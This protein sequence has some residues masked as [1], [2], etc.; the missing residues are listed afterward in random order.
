MLEGRKASRVRLAASG[1]FFESN[2]WIFCEICLPWFF[3]VL[4][5]LGVMHN[6]TLGSASDSMTAVAR[7][8]K[9]E[10]NSL[11]TDF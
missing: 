1:L 8:I 6:V 9:T 5:F 4:A 11:I 2:T 7:N 10:L 3:V